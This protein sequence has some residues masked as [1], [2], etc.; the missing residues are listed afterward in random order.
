MQ[1]TLTS[2]L[3]HRHAQNMKS[4]GSWRRDSSTGIRLSSSLN[5]QQP[6]V[7][8]LLDNFRFSVIVDLASGIRQKM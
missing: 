8:S 3:G 7:L 1:P 2:N 6:R 4:L 5:I